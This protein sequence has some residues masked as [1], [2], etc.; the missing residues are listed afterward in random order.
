M[1]L[2][3]LVFNK[4]GNSFSALLMYEKRSAQLWDDVKTR[5]FVISHVCSSEK[6]PFS[7]TLKTG[8][9][10]FYIHFSSEG[11][12]IEDLSFQLDDKEGFYRMFDEPEYIFKLSMTNSSFMKVENIEG[13]IKVCIP[14]H[15]FF[16]GL[17]EF[18]STVFL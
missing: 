8:T 1:E 18:I 16:K 6:T 11:F 7:V 4:L 10:T 12:S 15:D 9:K 2:Q 14:E 3:N 17:Y 13:K 5:Y